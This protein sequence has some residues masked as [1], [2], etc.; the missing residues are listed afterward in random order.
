MMNLYWLLPIIGVGHN[1]LG[2]G[3]SAPGMRVVV[4][5][6]KSSS[7]SGR[8]FNFQNVWSNFFNNLVPIH[9]GSK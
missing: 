2:S 1:M 6:Q 4:E 3:Y 8:R 5:K 9:I 7:M